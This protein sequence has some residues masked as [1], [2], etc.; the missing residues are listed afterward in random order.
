MKHWPKKALDGA[1]HQINL[2][3]SKIH[4]QADNVT[5][6]KIFIVAEENYEQMHWS[7]LIFAEENFGWVCRCA[8]LFF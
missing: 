6:I 2:S 5:S 3:D 1:T 8:C 4:G 7:Y